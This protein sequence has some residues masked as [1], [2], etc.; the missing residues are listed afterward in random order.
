[1]LIAD[2]LNLTGFNPLVGPN[3]ESWGVRFPH[4]AFAYAPDLLKLAEQA[5]QNCRIPLQK[6]VYAALLGPSLET[7]AEIRFLRTIG[8]DAVGLSTVHEVI[9]GVHAGMRILGI[10]IITNVHDPKNPA[11]AVL[12]E[13][14][15]TAEKSSKALGVLLR[16]VVEALHD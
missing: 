5:G 16:N 15:A 9:V 7:P 4:M 12:E 10:S 14:I 1:M 2:H 6:G 8:A 11:P 3:E 13:I